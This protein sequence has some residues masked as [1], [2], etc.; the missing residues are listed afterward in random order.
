MLLIVIGQE[1]LPDQAGGGGGGGATFVL[2]ADQFLIVAGG[3]G[4]G[5]LQ[6]LR[7]LSPQPRDHE[8]HKAN[9]GPAV[10]LQ[11]TE[12]PLIS[13]PVLRSMQNCGVLRTR[14]WALEPSSSNSVFQTVAESVIPCQVG[15]IIR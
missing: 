14:W 9:T 13:E 4:G 7:L 5:F 12:V 6:L 1:G 15:C 2:T 10:T 8:I 11:S 3:G